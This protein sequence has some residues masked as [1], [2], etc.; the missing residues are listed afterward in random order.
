MRSATTPA[1]VA[2]LGLLTVFSVSRSSPAEF[3][4]DNTPI[5]PVGTEGGPIRPLD[6]FETQRFLA[7]R[8]LFDRDFRISEGLGTPELNGDSC[9]ACHQTPEIGG[10]GGLDLN[11]FRFANDNGGQGPFTD[12]PGGQVASKLR[13]ATADGRD[14]Y[15]PFTA[16]VFEQRQTPALFGMGLIDGISD[17][18]ILL[19]EDPQDVDGDG[20]FGVARHVPIGNTGMTEVGRFGWKANIPHT[21]DFV[22][23]AMSGELGLTVPDNGRGFGELSDGDNVADPE[24]SDLDMGEVAFFLNHL[25]PPPRGGSNDPAVAQGEMLFAQVG[26]AT[27][28]TPTLLGAEGP[29]P[30]Y[31][32]LLLHN[33]MSANFRGMSEPGA[34]VGFYRTPPLWG[35]SRTA[36]YM[37]DGRAETLDDA[38]LHHAGEAQGAVTAYLALTVDEQNALQAFLADL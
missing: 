6:A 21:A 18:E 10:S 17:A 30:L 22:R 14:E 33:V 27:C 20:V 28:H 31:S 12:L 4:D 29:V 38:I 5:L 23:D 36:P 16:D 13:P 2:L 1:I 15:D 7:G 34:G 8:R 35:V 32:N 25:A 9:R 19:N 26:C 37:H 11:V 3:I 24:I